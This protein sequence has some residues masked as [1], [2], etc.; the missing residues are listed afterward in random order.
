LK[1]LSD[2]LTNR[3]PVR[4]EHVEPFV[5]IKIGAEP[6]VSDHGTHVAGIIGAGKPKEE[7]IPES[8]DKREYVPGM[9]P[10]IKLTTSGDRRVRRH[11]GHRV[12]DHRCLS[13]SAI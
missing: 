12:R 13:T 11:P 10:D 9:C 7:F 3:R 5:V 6:K 8:E 2:D 1:E 4:W